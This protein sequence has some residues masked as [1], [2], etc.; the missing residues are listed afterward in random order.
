MPVNKIV[1]VEGQIIADDETTIS[2]GYDD[3]TYWVE[4]T[5]GMPEVKIGSD[6]KLILEVED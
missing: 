6:C 1:I 3:Y 5:E 2:I 4:K